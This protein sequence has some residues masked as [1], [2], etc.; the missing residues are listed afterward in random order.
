MHIAPDH[1]A[2]EHEVDHHEAGNVFH[3]TGDRRAHAARHLAEPIVEPTEEP[4]LFQMM[5]RLH[6]LQILRAEGRRQRESHDDGQ[7]HRRHDRHRELTVNHTG[8]TAEEGHRNEH[9]GKHHGNTDQSTLNLAHRLDGRGLRVRPFFAHHAFDVF[10]DHDGVVHQEPDREH[11]SKHRKHVDGVP[12]RP[13]DAER[14][15]KHHR[16]G[17]RRNDRRTP[18]LQEEVHHAHHEDDGFDQ[19]LHHFFESGR[20]EGRR[21]EGVNHFH[22]FGEVRRQFRHLRAHAVGRSEGVRP[23][24]Q[25]NGDTRRRHAVKLT[26]KRVGFLTQPHLADILDA[27]DGT[28][29]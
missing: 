11:Q 1:G 14:P 7:N 22:P 17:D 9:S 16:H 21:I 26:F 3:K 28:V 20:H 12:Q 29:G 19:G 5:P 13:Q 27:H 18:V 15:Q 24:T 23:R 6:L 4:G 10:N 2:H 8:G 25:L